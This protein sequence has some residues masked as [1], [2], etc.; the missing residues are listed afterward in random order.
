MLTTYKLIMWPEIHCLQ[1]VTPALPPT[2][3]QIR[4]HSTVGASILHPVD[5]PP[6]KAGTLC[7]LD[8]VGFEKKSTIFTSKC[9]ART[10]WNSES[11][12]LTALPYSCQ[13]TSITSTI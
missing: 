6:T 1:M 9:A 12:M 11:N 4:S 5:V 2:L 8:N 7:Y 13:Y 10:L 3:L